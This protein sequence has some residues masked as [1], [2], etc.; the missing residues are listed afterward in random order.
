MINVSSGSDSEVS[1][2]DN[3]DYLDDDTKPTFTLKA[4]FD[5]IKDSSN[6]L[7]E[8][9]SN[10]ESMAPKIDH[11]Y[12]SNEPIPF[13]VQDELMSNSG[14]QSSVRDDTKE[15][16]ENELDGFENENFHVKAD[17]DASYDPNGKL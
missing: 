12:G 9:K 2:D 7:N 13:V 10:E 4:E 14:G 1:D 8:N 15:T 6:D 5:A 3:Y 17:N 16:T 11:V